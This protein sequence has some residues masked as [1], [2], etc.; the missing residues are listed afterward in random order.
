VFG[1]PDERLGGEVAVVV[2][3]VDGGTLTAEELCAF[4]SKK[5]AAC[6]IPSRVI[7][8][9]DPLPRNPAGKF[10]KRELRQGVVS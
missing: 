1:V 6:M 10:L 7:I 9:A 3:L 2:H 8:S 4:L 5:I